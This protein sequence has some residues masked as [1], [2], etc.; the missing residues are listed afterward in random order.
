MSLNDKET[1]PMR[2]S[3]KQKRKQVVDMKNL[4]KIIPISST[5]AFIVEKKSLINKKSI[6]HM[7]TNN[8][9]R[10]TTFDLNFDTSF[11]LF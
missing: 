1:L 8:K 11:F 7:E 10:T 6:N 9:T 3:T 2:K 5:Y 4:A